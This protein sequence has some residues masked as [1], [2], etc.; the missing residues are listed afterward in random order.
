MIGGDAG[1]RERALGDV[2]PVH[3][4]RIATT[5]RIRAR[6]A[7]RVGVV[8]Q[9]VGVEREDDAGLIELV[10][11]FDLGAGRGAQAGLSAL[12]A[13]WRPRDDTRLREALLQQR[14]EARFGRR[15]RRRGDDREARARVGDVL[16]VER[17]PMGEK[18]V[19]RLLGAAL[20]Y[21]A[22]A[23]GV[24]E[25]VDR[26][27]GERIG[28]ALRRRVQVVAFDLG[29]PALVADHQKSERVA[30]EGHRGRVALRNARQHVLGRLHV[31]HDLLDRTSARRQSGKRER[32]PHETEHGAPADAVRSIGGAFEK[33]AMADSLELG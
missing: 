21:D 10:D 20:Q 28:R 26:V 29:R 19:P 14:D 4:G 5:R 1:D 27:L 31:R 8:L 3:R 17:L 18:V 13:E 2:E 33:L 11:G 32:R 9:E 7:N 12:V 25:L 30:A 6:Q 16:G 24:I 15:A 22:R 23:V